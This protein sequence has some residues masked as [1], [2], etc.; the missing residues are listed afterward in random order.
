MLAYSGRIPGMQ[1]PP[2]CRYDFAGTHGR[3]RLYRAHLFSAGSATQSPGPT[4]P[5]LYREPPVSVFAGMSDYLH[6]WSWDP[7]GETWTNEDDFVGLEGGADFRGS[8]LRCAFRDPATGAMVFAAVP[9]CGEAMED[10]FYISGDGDTGRFEGRALTTPAGYR[11]ARIYAAPV[12][13]YMLTDPDFS[14]VRTE[15]RLVYH[16]RFTQIVYGI[17]ERYADNSD[18]GYAPDTIE[19]CENPFNYQNGFPHNAIMDNGMSDYGW[20]L[21]AAAELNYTDVG[22]WRDIMISIPAGDHI[23]T[24]G[25]VLKYTYLGGDYEELYGEAQTLIVPDAAPC[26]AAIA[27]RGGGFL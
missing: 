18:A 17:G 3:V 26:P 21:A 19:T 10:T 13:D 11:K 14:D 22:E 8:F 1:G 12:Y 20:S 9:E 16:D 24:A 5:L 6:R 4:T 2:R 27:V 23:I 7:M 15:T 25:T